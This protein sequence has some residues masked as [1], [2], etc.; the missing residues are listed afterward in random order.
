[1]LSDATHTDLF[2]LIAPE[3]IIV[4][5]ALAILGLSM[6]RRNDHAPGKSP[7]TSSLMAIAGLALAIW[8]NLFHQ[9]QGHALDWT[10]VVNPATQMVKAGLMLTG[11][12]LVWL[13]LACNQEVREHHAEFHALMLFALTGMALLIGSN[14]L[15]MIFVALE[16]TALSLYV[17]AAFDKRE[18]WKAR[19]ALKYFLIGGLSAAFVLYGFSL[20]YGVSGSMSLP[21]ISQSQQGLPI[22]PLLL[23]GVIMALVGFGFKIAA[24]PFHWWVADVYAST[25]TPVTGLIASASKIAGFYVIGRFLWHGFPQAAGKLSGFSWSQGWLPWIAAFSLLSMV[26][27]NLAALRQQ[28]IRR[29]IGFSAVAHTGYALLGLASPGPQAMASI[30]FYL[31][32]YGVS[33]IGFLAL[34]RATGQQDDRIEKGPLTG[35]WSRSPWLAACLMLLILS[36][37]GIPPLVGF[38]AKF[39]LFVAALNTPGN[40]MGW[41]ALVVLALGTSA[42]S[43][44]YYLGILKEAFCREPANEI[45]SHTSEATHS[46]MTLILTCTLI[47]LILGILPG[48]LLS[49]LVASFQQSPT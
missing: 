33:V 48:W 9:S 47:T 37:A 8:V 41:I 43:L 10:F 12:L 30:A 17:L 26:I 46:E 24:A 16:I 20:I 39:N 31:L 7:L 15:L 28:R 34:L 23:L 44:Y 49:T 5:T 29:L 19:N 32:S 42:V 36:L 21:L 45:P 27:G 38:L 2:R 14:H 3:C 13:H 6:G 35:L 18:S 11:I 22:D 40:F 25:L 1:M 4:V